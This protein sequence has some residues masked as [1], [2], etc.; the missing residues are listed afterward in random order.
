VRSKLR[1][2]SAAKIAG[3][4]DRTSH[5][6]GSTDSLFGA[7][8]AM[9]A[10]LQGGGGVGRERIDW[11]GLTASKSSTTSKAWLQRLDDHATAT[12]AQLAANAVAN[13]WGPALG[14]VLLCE[15]LEYL[16]CLECDVSNCKMF[17]AETALLLRELDSEMRTINPHGP[18]PGNS[19]PGAGA[20]GG[21]G[22]GEGVQ[23]PVDILTAAQRRQRFDSTGSKLSSSEKDSGSGGEKGSDPGANAID[24]PGQGGQAG[25]GAWPP[26][27]SPLSSPMGGETTGYRDRLASDSSQSSADKLSERDGFAPG[28]DAVV[29]IAVQQFPLPQFGGAEMRG[30]LSS[31]ELF[32]MKEGAVYGGQ[33]A[34]ACALRSSRPGQGSGRSLGTGSGRSLASGYSA[35]G[36][37]E[38]VCGHGG[39]SGGAR[40][41]GRGDSGEF[42]L[43]TI[44]SG[45]YPRD[46]SV[47]SSTSSHDALAQKR[48]VDV[49]N[50]RLLVHEVS[51][52]AEDELRLSVHSVDGQ[53][54][55]RVNTSGAESN[56]SESSNSENKRQE[57]STLV[58]LVEENAGECCRLQRDVLACETTLVS[59]AAQCLKQG[60]RSTLASGA[61]VFLGEEDREEERE[62][63]LEE[64]SAVAGGFGSRAGVTPSSGGG[65]ASMA[66][67]RPG[68]S[69]MVGQARRLG[70]ERAPGHWSDQWRE[71]LVPAL[72]PIERFPQ[73][74]AVKAQYSPSKKMGDAYTNYAGR[75]YNAV[76]CEVQGEDKYLVRASS[77]QHVTGCLIATCHAHSHAHTVPLQRLTRVTS[78]TFSSG[79]LERRCRRGSGE[80]ARADAAGALGAGQWREAGGGGRATRCRRAGRGDDARRLRPGP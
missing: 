40:Q 76:I 4:V 80:D 34:R 31:D 37:D 55:P 25:Q 69:L 47:G 23:C 63:N 59:L 35:D 30:R 10:A 61:N 42:Q 39:S 20:G 68:S 5:Q 57:R 54:R 24:E 2:T 70:T 65:S 78:L 33:G 27:W 32:A 79:A 12:V 43:S 11:S 28:V 74:T 66:R 9:A 14:Q 58:R 52:A 21:G 8:S 77:A 19:S 29:P 36:S 1:A 3:G 17:A 75:W 18:S 45:E 6:D 13:F 62:K 48:D 38:A 53:G 64:V 46:S 44:T 7:W 16:A 71:R 26:R 72:D 60:E 56:G 49:E 41:R 15:T 22:G 51:N 50:L 67:G 73:G